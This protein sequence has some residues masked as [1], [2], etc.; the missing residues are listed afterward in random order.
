MD[1]IYSLSYFL[2]TWQLI[3]LY[4]CEFF[5]YGGVA[6]L[7]ACQGNADQISL[8]YEYTDHKDFSILF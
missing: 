8:Y 2:N 7:Y 3:Y 5:H 6:C 4:M 1:C